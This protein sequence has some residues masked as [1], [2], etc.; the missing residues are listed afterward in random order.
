[1]R[2]LCF[3]TICFCACTTESHQ[4]QLFLQTVLDSISTSGI[5]WA[6]SH[7]HITTDFAGAEQVV[8]PQYDRD[9]A[10]AIIFPHLIDLKNSGVNTLMECTPNYIGRD[11]L[12]LRS[13]AESV[14]MHILTNT[15]YY[16]AVEKKFLP[17]HAYTESAQQLATR[18][19]SESENGIEGTEIKPGFIKIGFD[20]GSLDTLE[21]KILQ[22]AIIT[23]KTTGLTIAIHCG[24]GIPAWESFEFIRSDGLKG[25][26]MIWVHAQN[27]TLAENLALAKNG[28][29]VSIDGVNKSNLS[30]YLQRILAFQEQDL[31]DHLLISHDDGWWVTKN[32]ETEEISLD[33]FKEGAPYLSIPDLLIPELTKAGLSNEQLDQ[34]LRENP[35]RAFAKKSDPDPS[36]Y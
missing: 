13:L 17:N 3:I 31:L 15:G 23:H 19:I 26:A 30:I 6:L 25:S 35:G 21:Q 1:M 33:P 10:F 16:A 24:N 11:I 8:Q 27:A 22:A 28:V 20:G 7:E 9:S 12:L 34:I 14:G 18:W 36:V 4:E 32:E 2:F 29:W 5:T